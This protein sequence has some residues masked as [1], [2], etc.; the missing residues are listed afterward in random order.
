[1]SSGWIILTCWA[2]MAI[3]LYA[4]VFRCVDDNETNDIITWYLSP[5]SGCLCLCNSCKTAG[6]CEATGVARHLPQ[7]WNCLH[8]FH[9]I[10]AYCYWHARFILINICS[11]YCSWTVDFTFLRATDT[12]CYSTLPEYMKAVIIS[13]Y[14]QDV[15]T[16]SVVHDPPGNVTN[17]NSC[18]V[19]PSMF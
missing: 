6:M 14:S 11:C 10:S 15:N 18:L 19:A 13:F 16:V 17:L 12:L 5:I 1:M 3:C 4:G 7:L 2:R 8:S 9:T